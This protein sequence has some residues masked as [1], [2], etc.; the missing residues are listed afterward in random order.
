MGLPE[1]VQIPELLVGVGEEKKYIWC[2]RVNVCDCNR[3][4]GFDLW[5]S[6]FMKEGS[7]SENPDTS[8]TQS[9]GNEAA[10]LSK[11]F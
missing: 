1:G 7:E 3:P 8:F 2:S 4:A 9:M 6:V 10:T 11:L 5:S